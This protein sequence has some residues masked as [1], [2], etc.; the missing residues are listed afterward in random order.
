MYDENWGRIFH[1]LM[2][3]K[4]DPIQTEATS[5]LIKNLIESK[6]LVELK[7]SPEMV[8]QN[9]FIHERRFFILTPFFL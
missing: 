8:V 4:Y 2:T 3:S 9:S 6:S 5:L 7:P 1:A